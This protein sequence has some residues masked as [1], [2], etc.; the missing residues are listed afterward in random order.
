MQ[1]ARFHGAID[2][3]FWVMREGAYDTIGH[4]KVYESI[5]S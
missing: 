3:E 4:A 1:E 2:Q 5:D